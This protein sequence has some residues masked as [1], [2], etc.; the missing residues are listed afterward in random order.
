MK[1]GNYE[2]E[3]EFVLMLFEN[4]D[5]LTA[6]CGVTMMTCVGKES[7]QQTTKHTARIVL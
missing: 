7:E 5:E 1:E 6:F 4:T 2:T 3:S